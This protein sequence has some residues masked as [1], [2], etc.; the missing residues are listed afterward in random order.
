MANTYYDSQ[1]TA[2]E[3][4]EVLEA[5]N[6]ILTSANNGKVLAISNGRFEARSVQ[7]GGG[8]PTIEPL[9]VT[10]NG[11]Y[12]APSGVDGYSPITVNV[13]GGSKSVTVVTSVTGGYNGG[14]VISIAIDGTTVF[15]ATAPDTY[16][17]N[18]NKTSETVDVDGE[19]V[20]I[21]ITPPA[22]TTSK[23]GISISS[24]VDALNYQVSPD[25]QNTSYGY[26]FSDTS[27]LSMPQGSGAVVQPLS[28]TQN[29]TYNP[30]SG[31]DGYAPV[32]VNVSG[33]G[34]IPSPSIP[35]EYQ[36]VKYLSLTGSSGQYI[37]I[38]GMIENAEF[39]AIAQSK[40]GGEYP[41][42][43][44]G[45]GS[46]TSDIDFELVPVRD[47]SSGI[48]R[49]R[50]WVRGGN[51][52]GK[53]NTADIITEVS[54]TIDSS[55]YF[56]VTPIIRLIGELYTTY[57]DNQIFIGKYKQGSSPYFTGNIYYVKFASIA[58]GNSVKEFVPC[59]RKSDGVPGFYETVNNLFYTNDGSGTFGVGPDV[60]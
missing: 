31:V 15:T 22:T 55:G 53:L 35:T 33:G 1:L 29:G 6:G 5:I 40:D 58:T 43:G 56:L 49:G 28:A 18:Y 45:A 47:D 27:T 41:V 4:E 23:L 60:N 8:E 38:G 30:P 26:S 11:T 10:A 42:V 24:S 17:Q 37:N 34:G 20:D 39:T 12:T 51:S 2:A 44:G 59:Y 16:N 46:G 54:L 19:N 3:I 9:S 48:N 25:G 57:N 21:L 13:S 14:A 50:F 32:V 36:K 7:W 52:Y